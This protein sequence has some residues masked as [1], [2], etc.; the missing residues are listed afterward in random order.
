MRVR[1]SPKSSAKK[2]EIL[3]LLIFSTPDA[4]LPRY[5]AGR[6][7]QFGREAREVNTIHLEP[8][9]APRFDRSRDERADTRP[10]RNGSS[11]HAALRDR[12]ELER[13]RRP[14][15]LDMPAFRQD[16][17]RQIHE[18]WRNDSDRLPGRRDTVAETAMDIDLPTLSRSR[19]PPGSGSSMYSDRMVEVEKRHADRLPTAPRAMHSKGSGPTSP[20]SNMLP[21][22]QAGRRDFDDTLFRG[23]SPKV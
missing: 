20:A 21:L 22:P 6:S 7:S 16:V 19:Y 18:G 1:S 11:A 10:L 9:Q 3:F 17:G 5:A 15:T 8:R 23:M 12:N 4:K 13:E 14:E 2:C